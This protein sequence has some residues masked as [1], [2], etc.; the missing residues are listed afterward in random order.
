MKWMEIDQ[1]YLRCRNCNRLS[2]F[3][4]ALAQISCLHML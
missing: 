1:D 3:L 4:W 2:C